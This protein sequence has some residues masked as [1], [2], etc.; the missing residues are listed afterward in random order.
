MGIFA[1][2][3]YGVSGFVDGNG[4]QFVIQIIGVLALVGWVVVT[5]GV[6]FWALNKTMGLRASREEELGGL[7]VP[8]HGMEAYPTEEPLTDLMAEKAGS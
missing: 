2:G 6:M 5:A 3:S 7:D 1:D 4:E 8:E